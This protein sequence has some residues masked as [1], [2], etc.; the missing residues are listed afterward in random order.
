MSTR[1]WPSRDYA[2]L[3]RPPQPFPPG[4]VDR[5]TIGPAEACGH[6]G[7]GDA[8]GV[9][10]RGLFL[11]AEATIKGVAQRLLARVVPEMEAA[12]V[13]GV[14]E[15]HLRVGIRETEGAAQAR[16]AEGPG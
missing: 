13:G 3:G 5:F 8:G 15:A 14:G 6:A 12:P 9:A 4:G 1:R 7:S 2:P 11:D 16:G 10:D